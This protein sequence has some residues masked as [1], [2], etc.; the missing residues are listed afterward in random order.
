MQ[1]CNQLSHLQHQAGLMAH[2][3]SANL[4]KSNIIAPQML[5]SEMEVP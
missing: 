1:L 5:H 4:H 3:T 2:S